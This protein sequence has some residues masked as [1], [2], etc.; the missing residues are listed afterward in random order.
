MSE[1]NPTKKDLIL[2]DTLI[3]DIKQ[4]KSGFINS[5]IRLQNSLSQLKAKYKDVDQNSSEFKKIKNTR[6]NIKNHLN[7]LELKIKGLNDEIA[8]KNKLR[9]EIEFHIKHH[10]QLESK[11][12]VD[13]IN[14]KINAL[15][16]KYNDF[17]KDK[18]RIASLRIMACE[19]VDELNELIDS[20]K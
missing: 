5:K 18:T 12:D 6:D 13:K 11:E 10:K 20:I 17:A 4:K 8:Y 19:F 2:I 15:K 3:L 16:I 9:L 7:G 1:F 14:I